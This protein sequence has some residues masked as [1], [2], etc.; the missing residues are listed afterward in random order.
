MKKA[1][2]LILAAIM[3]VTLVACGEGSGTVTTTVA[4]VSEAGNLILAADVDD[5]EDE[6]IVPGNEVIIEIG[7]YKVAMLYNKNVLE[8]RGI[9]QM[10]ANEGKVEIFTYEESFAEAHGVKAEDTV[11]ITKVKQPEA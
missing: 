5:L 8:G 9:E 11:I 3:M 1:V 4:E 7:E 10:Y 6:G 2:L